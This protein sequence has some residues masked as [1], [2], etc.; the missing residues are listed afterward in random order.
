[1]TSTIK[2]LRNN[3]Y[4]QTLFVI[5]LIAVVIFSL[6]FGAQSILNTKITPALAVVSGSMCI[7]YGG[8]CDGWLSVNHP[9]DRTL[10]TGDLIIIQGV[11]PKT[12]NTDYPNSD[13]IVYQHPWYPT[14]PNEKVVHR[15]V[16]TTEINDT[17]HFY[18]KGDGNPFNKWP[19]ALSTGDHDPWSP[20]SEDLIYGKVIMRIPW[21]GHLPIFVQS[22]SKGLGFNASYIIVLLI[23]IALVLLV[24]AEFIV[25]LLRRRHM[26]RAEHTKK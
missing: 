24:V 11:D 21:V 25:P 12:L 3:D 7:P 18:T 1:M 23:V 20:V 22:A 9:F 4:F 13:I 10:H 15:I 5:A 8:A 19:S 17:L 16:G 6:W 14:D 2:K 26:I